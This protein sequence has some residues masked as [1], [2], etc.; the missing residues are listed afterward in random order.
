M[1]FR[2]PV[3]KVLEILYG[4]ELAIQMMKSKKPP[5]IITMVD[6]GLCHSELA[7]DAGWGLYFFK[8]LFA[9]TTEAGS[10][11]LVAGVTAG[12]DGHG[13][14]MSGSRIAE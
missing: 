9:R 6:P 3:S 12:A 1:E 13:Q 4:R 10:R 11:T 5:V 14:Y 8:L 7:R 2:Y